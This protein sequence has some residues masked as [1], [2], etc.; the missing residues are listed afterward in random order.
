MTDIQQLVGELVKK[1]GTK[2]EKLLPILQGVIEKERSLSDYAMIEIA[3][4]LGISA[5]DVYGTATF[6]SFM[7]TEPRGENIIRVC[8]T[9]TCFMKGKNQILLALEDALKIKLGE[10][11]PDKKFTLLETNCLGW[12]HKAPAMLINDEIYTDLTIERV[13]EIIGEYKNK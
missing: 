1:H 3:K 5:A 2:R 4:Q 6:Y 13:H 7:D 10:T 11:T 8:K 12:C 9:I